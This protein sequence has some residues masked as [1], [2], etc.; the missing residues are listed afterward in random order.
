M[1]L[2]LTRQTH[3][4]AGQEFTIEVPASQ[5][6][7]LE[8]ALGYD[9]LQAP[10][11]DPYW[12]LLWDAAPKT[13]SVILQHDWRSPLKVLDLGC[14][15]GLTGIAALQAGHRV[16]FADHASMAVAIAMSNAALNGFPDTRGLV[17]DWQQPPAE[18]FEFIIA[19]DVLYDVSSHPTLL[20]TLQT[21][22]SEDGFVWIG[23]AGRHNS[24]LFAEF[25]VRNGWELQTLSEAGTPCSNCSH[26]QFHILVLKRSIATT[27]DL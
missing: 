2:Q 20:H 3:R 23:D 14:G 4:I 8:H 17:F 11:A 19:S 6:H 5:E 18:G 1:N 7:L 25:A 24:F 27:Q 12:G 9:E 10:D 21:M 26:L 16:T 13:A 22:L 15:I